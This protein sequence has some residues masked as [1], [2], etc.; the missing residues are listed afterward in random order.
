MLGIPFP[1]GVTTPI[2]DP[3]L[4]E[5][6]KPQEF[7][8]WISSYFNPLSSPG[9]ITDEALRNR[10][11]MY[12]ATGDERYLPI[13]LRLKPSELRS[14]VYPEAYPRIG[15]MLAY[16]PEV[17]GQ[18]LQNAIFDTKGRWSHLRVVGLW[19]DMTIWTCSLTH[20][21]LS[22]M[23]ATPSAAGRVRRNVEM[24][25]LHDANHIVST[26]RATCTYC[27]SPDLTSCRPIWKNQRSLYDYWPLTC[28]TDILQ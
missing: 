13:S 19:P 21:A 8:R 17:Y 15:I 12:E 23:L 27:W 5:T 1:P 16:A 7:I 11:D 10:H 9:D 28:N 20:R 2:H 18:A 26:G 25:E 24:V 14:I 3:T 4:P 6:E 22:D